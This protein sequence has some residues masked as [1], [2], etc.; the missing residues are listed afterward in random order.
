MTNP[1]APKSPTSLVTSHVTSH[2]T[3]HL[4][5]TQNSHASIQQPY[6]NRMLPGAEGE[7]SGVADSLNLIFIVG[8]ALVITVLARHLSTRGRRK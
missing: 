2:V 6:R 8:L 5:N 4:L 1:T 7:S 3:I